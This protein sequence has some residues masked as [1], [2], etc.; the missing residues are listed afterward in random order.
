[1]NEWLLFKIYLNT[2]DLMLQTAIQASNLSSRAPN[3][4]YA[5]AIIPRLW[6]DL[7]LIPECLLQLANRRG[8]YFC[9]S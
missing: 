8:P 6:N 7:D 9:V 2:Y 3:V 1:M 5:I 4:K